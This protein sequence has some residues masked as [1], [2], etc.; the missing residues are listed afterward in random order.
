M[1]IVFNSHKLF[2][3]IFKYLDKFGETLEMFTEIQPKIE[4]VYGQN[5]S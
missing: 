1:M 3:K 2:L 5:S 4:N